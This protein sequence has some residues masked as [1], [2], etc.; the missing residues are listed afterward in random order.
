MRNYLLVLLAVLTASLRIS[1]LEI[2]G[3]EYSI[4]SVTPPEV[5][6][7]GPAD[8]ITLTGD[9]V[10][11]AMV[12]RPSD[13]V[14]YKVVEI[15]HADGN[16]R[17]EMT[18]AP[19]F[20]NQAGIRS[21]TIPEGV[22]EIWYDSFDGCNGIADFFVDDKNEHFM[23]IDG[24]LYYKSS[25]GKP[26]A[27]VRFPPAKQATSFTVPDGIPGEMDWASRFVKYGAFR[28]NASINTLILG[29]RVI[30]EDGA[31]CGNLGIKMIVGHD[32]YTQNVNGMLLSEDG[33]TLRHLPPACTYG[34]L[35]IPSTV[36]TLGRYSCASARCKEVNFNNV[37]KI[38]NQAF[39]GA[40]LTSVTVPATVT[41]IE[42]GVFRDCANL[43]SAKFES[44]IKVVRTYMFS[45]CSRLERVELPTSCKGVYGQAFEGCTSLKSFSLANM[46]TANA[47]GLYDSRH[48]AS[49]GIEKVN[50]PSGI[51][52]IENMMYFNCKNLTSLSL[53][54][55][56]ERIKDLAFYG[57]SI[58]TFNS[59]NLFEIQDYAFENC[60]KLR[61]IVLADSDHELEL[62]VTCFTVNPG[63]GIYLDHKNLA[64]GGWYG[65]DWT[66]AFYGRIDKASFYISALRPDIFFTMETTVYCPG[67]VSAHYKNF[68]S[69]NNVYEMFGY[70]KDASGK[71][72][73]SP[74][75][76]WVKIK[77]VTNDGN[78][79]KVEYTANGV[80]MTTVYPHDFVA[81]QTSG[82]AATEGAL[83][84]LWTVCDVAGRVVAT[85]TSYEAAVAG[86]RRGTYIARCGG[87]SRKI[88]VG[89]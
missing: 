15:G 37:T 75:Y 79:A 69:R 38:I 76:S 70:S 72:T 31:L 23:S 54:P 58:E 53:K 66:Y 71:V 44:R 10:L 52:D 73:I 51:A 88:Y 56:T 64:F 39:K 46:T 74:N 47:E 77:S 18:G 29:K 89:R 83:P 59:S 80:S 5:R 60:N 57:T 2:D 8:G 41:E 7:S 87:E 81:D 11:P 55:T 40:A 82:L 61:K 65:S 78:S 85:G 1:A 12:V 42:Y 24:V 22:K 19:A 36:T 4:L 67:G 63:A 33:T 34:V 14:S 62:G 84:G 13:G 6:I 43:V 35:T 48:F 32:S 25:C 3:F 21:V 26:D 9:I 86:L 20:R 68:N 49:S 28:G 30:L 16:V 27:L 50:W 17:D 45:G